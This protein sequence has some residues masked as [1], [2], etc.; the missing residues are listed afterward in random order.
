VVSVP[1]FPSGGYA[2]TTGFMQ[3][4][5]WSTLILLLLFGDS[6]TREPNLAF[7]KFL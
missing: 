7:V 6:S 2:I 5:K 4:K 3:C 1:A